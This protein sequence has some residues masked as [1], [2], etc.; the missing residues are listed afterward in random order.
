MGEVYARAIDLVA[1]RRVDVASLVTH[2][3]ALEAAPGVFA[4]LADNQPGFVKALIYPNGQ[5]STGSD[6]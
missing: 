4:A 1:S 3:V 6:S 5:R 2:R